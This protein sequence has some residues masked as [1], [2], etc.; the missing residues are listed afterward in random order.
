LKKTKKICSRCGR[1]TN[2]EKHHII[3]KSEGGKDTSDNLMFLCD[4]CHDFKHAERNILHSIQ[5]NYDSIKYWTE[6]CSDLIALKVLYRIEYKIKRIK[7]LNLRLETLRELNSVINIL[8]FGYRSYWQKE[9]T[10]GN[11]TRSKYRRKKTKIINR[12]LEEVKD[13]D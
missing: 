7:L 10:H 8:Q 9:E 11:R 2:I 3:L 12:H 5:H 6:H 1:T 13:I 4:N